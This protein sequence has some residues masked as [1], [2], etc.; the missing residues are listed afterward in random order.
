MSDVE[1][2]QFANDIGFVYQSH[3][4]CR[5]FSAL[6]K[7]RSWLPQMIR[8]LKR[9]E[10]I[11]RATEILA[12]PASRPHHHR[13]GAVGRGGEQHAWRFA[14]PRVAKRTKRFC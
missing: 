3:R 13:R 7:K 10:L 11:K 9:S 4:F 5:E 1:R 12:Y 14:A 6:E 2:T 8:G